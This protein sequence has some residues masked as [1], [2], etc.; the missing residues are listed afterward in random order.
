MDLVGGQVGR[1][2]RCEQLIVVGLAIR[3]GGDTR[4][5]LVRI[6][7][8]RLHPRDQ[9]FIRRPEIT[10]QDL[11]C[12]IPVGIRLLGRDCSGLDEGAELAVYV[13][14]DRRIVTV[15]EGRPGDDSAG[16]LQH[17]FVGESRRPDAV[18]RIFLRA[19]D[20]LIQGA[21]HSR[22]PFD[23]RIHV[24]RLVDT[25]KVPH[26]RREHRLRPEEMGKDVIAAAVGL[27]GRRILV[28]VF[29][30]VVGHLCVG[31]QGRII[32]IAFH[33]FNRLAPPFEAL[34]FG[35]LGHVIDF[36][37]ALL[38]AEHREPER[39]H[40]KLL[41]EPRLEPFIEPLGFCLCRL[42]GHCCRRFGRRGL[43]LRGR[44][45]AGRHAHQYRE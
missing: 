41:L 38:A 29:P 7:D 23:V 31:R 32:E 10:E 26:E 21:R 28:L 14:P 30:D 39:A 27:A 37:V 16:L 2:V 24:G 42:G 25:V 44:L 6:P 9:A 17:P 5:L 18:L 45:A 12:R 20:E 36:I 15:A 43:G 34:V 35:V 40:Q 11:A 13:A 22:E 3:Q 1:R 19:V 4:W 8:V 33:G